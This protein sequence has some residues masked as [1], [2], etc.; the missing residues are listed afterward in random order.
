MSYDLATSGFRDFARSVLSLEVQPIS[1]DPL[2]G[3]VDG[4]NNVFHTNYF[5]ILTSGSLGVYVNGSLVSGSADFNTGEVTLVAAPTAQ[6]YASY[7]FTPYTTFQMLQF[8]FRGF[9]LMEGFWQR[10]YKLVDSSGSPATETSSAILVVDSTGNDPTI[11]GSIHFSQSAS[12]VAFLMA[13]CDYS[14]LGIQLSSSARSAFMWRETVRGMTVDKSM[15]PKNLK[16]AL[17]ALKEQLDE[18]LDGAQTEVF[19]GSQYGGIILGPVT[20]GYLYSFE[21]QSE[22]LVN[23]YRN[24]LGYQYGYRPIT[25]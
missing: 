23:D 1:R 8:M 20:L 24:T 14:L 25:S 22:S 19:E 16:L 17:D 4:S 11:T 9:S 18:L 7:T 3:V 15:M 5:P 12:Q 6:P 13:C 10:G 21:W 2:S